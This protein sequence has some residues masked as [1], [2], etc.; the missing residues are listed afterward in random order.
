MI[1][2]FGRPIKMDSYEEE[3][4]SSAEGAPRAAI[5]RITRA[6]ETELLAATINA[7]D[8]YVSHIHGSHVS[9]VTIGIPFMPPEWLAICF[10]KTLNL[11]TWTNLSQSRRRRRRFVFF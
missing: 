9:Y 10:G 8:W 11:S 1:G 5:K 6:I 4:F 7:P 3:F 2:R